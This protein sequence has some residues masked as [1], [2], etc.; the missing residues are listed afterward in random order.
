MN[1]PFFYEHMLIKGL[2]KKPRLVKGSERI[3]Y[4]NDEKKKPLRRKLNKWG[5]KI[6]ETNEMQIKQIVRFPQSRLT[7]E[8]YA[9]CH[10]V[11]L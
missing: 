11:I 6:S 9:R 4:R 1:I 2:K 7:I 5:S 8:T 3:F 10:R